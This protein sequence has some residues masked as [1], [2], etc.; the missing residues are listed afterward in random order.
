VPVK[1]HQADVQTEALLHV[2]Q[3][4]LE[5]LREQGLLVLRLTAQQIDERESRIAAVA[6]HDA[7][8]VL[9]GVFVGVLA[10][11]ELRIGHR[12][13]HHSAPPQRNGATSPHMGAPAQWCRRRGRI[14]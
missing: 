10:H 2:G 3:R 14:C 12:A 4:S 13:A 6:L 11:L 8:V 5:V 1:V 7:L 9:L